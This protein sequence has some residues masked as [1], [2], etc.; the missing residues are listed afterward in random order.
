MKKFN[1]TYMLL[2][3]RCAPKRRGVFYELFVFYFAYWI[4]KTIES[5]VSSI[6]QSILLLRDEAFRELLTDLERIQTLTAE[7]FM[8]IFTDAVLRMPEW[9]LLITLFATAVTAVGAIFVCVKLGKRTL[10][11]MGL[12]RRGAVGE[13]ALGFVIGALLIALVALIANGADALSF[14]LNRDVKLPMLGLFLAAFL[15][16]GLSEELLCRGYLMMNLTRTVSPLAA[17]LI[18]SLVFTVLHTG[19]IAVTPLALLNIALAGIVFGT[20]MLKRGSIWGAAAMHAAW[21]FV[22]GNVLGVP[23]SGMSMG[24]SLF[25]AVAGENRAHVSGGDFG[26]EG[27]LA[28]TIVLLIAIGALAALPTKN[29]EIVDVR[30]EARPNTHGEEQI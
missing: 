29:S 25:T 14:T 12:H 28:V 8:D 3:A 27:G 1:M 11:G 26:P 30:V 18:S 13:Y 19:N 15:I 16:Q 20:Y 2:D 6:P 22:Q 10:T 5:I 7:E 4:L 9:M 17:V 23:V 21:N 24:A